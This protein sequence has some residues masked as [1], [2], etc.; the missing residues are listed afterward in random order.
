MGNIWWTSDTHFYHANVI[1]Y[2]K[3]PFAN[4]EEMN[5][6]LV[7]N[8]V[9]VVQPGDTIYHLGDFSFGRK[10]QN[11]ALLQQL[12]GHKHLILGNHDK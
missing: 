11:E 5:A 7:R 12:H 4:V 2:S 3:R 10:E 9:A 1:K 6:A 8:W